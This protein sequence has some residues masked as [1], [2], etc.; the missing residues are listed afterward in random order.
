MRDYKPKGAPTIMPS[1]TVSNMQRSIDFYTKA[2]GFKLTFKN[3]TQNGEITYADLDFLD[4]RVML[5]PEGAYGSKSKTPAHSGQESPVSLYIYC[6]DVDAHHAQ[7]IASGAKELQP[8]KE[9]FWGD[10]MYSAADPDGHHWAFAQNVAD[11]DPSKVP[12]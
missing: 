9:M 4:I 10:R 8:L 2:F 11:F 1:I 12:S 7:A 3:T 6:H 5:L